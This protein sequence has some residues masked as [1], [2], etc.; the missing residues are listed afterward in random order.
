MFLEYQRIKLSGGNQYT[1]PYQGSAKGFNYDTEFD[2]YQITNGRPS[3]DG[4]NDHHFTISWQKNA[5]Y[6]MD[7]WVVDIQQLYLVDH[8]IP[9]WARL[10]LYKPNRGFVSFSDVCSPLDAT[11]WL[12]LPDYKRTL[13]QDVIPAKKF[14]VE[15]INIQFEEDSGVN[16]FT[17]PTFLFPEEAR[18]SITS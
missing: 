8:N 17:E 2:Y 7:G 15:E 16:A 1:R 14:R 5:L 3:F 11:N 4:Y 18:K 9:D 10:A 6:N 12:Y 13:A